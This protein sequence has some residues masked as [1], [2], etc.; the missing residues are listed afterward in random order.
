MRE[1]AKASM[2]ITG[3]KSSSMKRAERGLNPRGAVT[4]GFKVRTGARC[5]R[6]VAHPG[7]HCCCGHHGHEFALT[8]YIPRGRGVT[9]CCGKTVFELPRTERITANKKYRTCNP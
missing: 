2:N 1:E 4:C 6:P 5:S 8:H 3:K 9:A 7:G